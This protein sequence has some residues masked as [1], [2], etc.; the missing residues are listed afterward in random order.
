M[1]VVEALFNQLSKEGTIGRLYIQGDQLACAV[2]AANCAL[3]S[4]G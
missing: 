4:P 2:G 3:S 1:M